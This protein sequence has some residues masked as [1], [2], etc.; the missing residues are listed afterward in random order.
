VNAQ[1]VYL[2]L[3]VWAAVAS[4]TAVFALLS[5][6]RAN[7]RIRELERHLLDAPA[8]GDRSEIYSLTN[9]LEELG[10]QVDRLTESQDFLSR[11]LS[12][13]PRFPQADPSGESPVVTPRASQ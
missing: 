1:L 13:R 6:R 12:D 2:Q 5:L 8:A 4:T 11:Q 9:Q 10:V 3:L 7:R